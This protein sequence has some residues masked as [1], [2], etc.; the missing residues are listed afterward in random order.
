MTAFIV[1]ADVATYLGRSL[2]S[3][4]TAQADDVIDAACNWIESYCARSFGTTAVTDEAHTM[5]DGV[6]YLG[7]P[8]TSVASVKTITPYVGAQATLLA[9]S[10]WSLWDASTGKILVSGYGNSDALVSYT[11][12]TTV[13][14]GVILAAEILSA[15]WLAA[16]GTDTYQQQGIKSYSVG[17]ELSVTYADTATVQA[18]PPRVTQLLA[19]YKRAVFA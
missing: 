5:I 19:S 1:A 2:T 17:A 18:V 16:T 10:Q 12:S 3:A 9:S 14:A 6:I 15:S 11:P 7:R 4:E 8:V 13:P